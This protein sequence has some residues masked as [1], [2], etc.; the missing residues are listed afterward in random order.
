MIKTDIL[1]VVSNN[2]KGSKR[3]IYFF[4]FLSKEC[5][6]VSTVASG[7]MLTSFIPKTYFSYVEFK[8]IT[9]R[10]LICDPYC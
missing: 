2:G 1:A 6:F 4:Q 8:I 3:F 7:R 9:T 5:N 10:Q